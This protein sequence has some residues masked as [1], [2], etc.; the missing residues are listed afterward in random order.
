MTKSVRRRARTFKR[1]ESCGTGI[2]AGE[3]Y[4]AHSCSPNHDGLGNPG[5]WHLAECRDCAIRVGRWAA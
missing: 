5:W 1:C 3:E 2:A 4:L